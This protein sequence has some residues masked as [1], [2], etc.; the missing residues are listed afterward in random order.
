[1]DQG[2]ANS[3]FPQPSGHSRPLWP[4]AGAA[5][6]SLPAPLPPWDQTKG[7]IP[8]LL[9]IALGTPLQSSWNPGLLNGHCSPCYFMVPKVSQVCVCTHLCTCVHV[10]TLMSYLPH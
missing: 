3:A 2:Y 10:C 5:H 8:K 1:M 9:L 4:T 6:F 7:C